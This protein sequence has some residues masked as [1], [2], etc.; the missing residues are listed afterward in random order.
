MRRL[1]ALCLILG[2][3]APALAADPPAAEDNQ[4]SWFGR[5]ILGM[6]PKEKPPQPQANAARDTAATPATPP[7]R[8]SVAKKWAD[9]QKI[10]FE[11]LKAITKIRTL[12]SEQGDEAMLKKADDLEAQ[13]EEL[14]RLRTA[15]LPVPAAKDDQAALERGRDERPASASRNSRRNNRGGDQ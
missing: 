3:A 1:G 10:Y 8:E 12:A 11:R 4:P 14:Y 2:L 6:R 7:A 9:E 13:A 5:W 15:K